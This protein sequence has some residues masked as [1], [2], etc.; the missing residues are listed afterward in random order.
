MEAGRQAKSLL[1]YHDSE[2]GYHGDSVIGEK[3]SDSGHICKTG[4]S[5]ADIW[6]RVVKEM[7][8]S[9]MILWLLGLSNGINGF[10]VS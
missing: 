7:E 1:K 5:V 8:K 9:K 2:L 3:W 10:A 4:N 6:V